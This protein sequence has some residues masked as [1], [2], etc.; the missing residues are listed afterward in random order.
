MIFAQDTADISDLGH[1]TNYPGNVTTVALQLPT[2]DGLV[3]EH[4]VLYE[5][6]CRQEDLIG[7]ED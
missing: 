7:L 3:P 4:T 1:A 2:R 5:G 6:G